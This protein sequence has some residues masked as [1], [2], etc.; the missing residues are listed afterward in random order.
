[1]VA[2]SESDHPIELVLRIHDR[3]HNEDY[4]DRFNRSLTFQPGINAFRIP[5]D[6]IRAAP[7]GREMDL[8]AI[9]R[10]SVFAVAPE[11]QLSLYLLELRL[12]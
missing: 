12:E 4:A 6:E 1:L 2:R 9:E 7:A 8:S 10:L 11:A 3:R 5:L